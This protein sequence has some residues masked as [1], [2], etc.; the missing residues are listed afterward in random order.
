MTRRRAGLKRPPENDEDRTRLVRLRKWTLA[1]ATA[2]LEVLDEISEWIWLVYG[3]QIQQELRR[4]CEVTKAANL[5]KLDDEDVPF[6][7]SH[8]RISDFRFTLLPVNCVP[9]FPPLFPTVS[10]ELRPPEVAVTRRW[11]LR[12]P[13]L[14]GFWTCEQKPTEIAPS[15]WSTLQQLPLSLLSQMQAQQVESSYSF[16]ALLSVSAQRV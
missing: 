12:A 8:G 2:V 11:G 5:A 15:T 10:V 7:R 16:R 13:N 3:S 4:D 1:Q 6:Y 9:S 14:T